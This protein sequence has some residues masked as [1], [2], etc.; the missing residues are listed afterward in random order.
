MN[1]DPVQ[2]GPAAGAP[3]FQR[4]QERCTEQHGTSSHAMMIAL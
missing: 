1:D 4:Q 3:R 2:K